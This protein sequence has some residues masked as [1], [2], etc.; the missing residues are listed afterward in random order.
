MARDDNTGEIVALHCTYD[1]ETKGGQAPDKRKVRGTIHW[2]S[3]P[4][5]LEVEVRLY[6]YLFTVEKPD[7]VEDYSSVLNPESLTVLT[8]CKI[9]SRVADASPGSHYQFERLGYFCVDSHDSK[10]GG[11]VFNRTVTL[12]DSWAKIESRS[13][14]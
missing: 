2:V 13:T 3:A 12:R 4:H 8:S 5:A 9:E 10:P 7:E 1:P 11:L 14:G 6:E